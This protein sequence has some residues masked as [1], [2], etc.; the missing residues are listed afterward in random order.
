MRNDEIA[1]EGTQQNTPSLDIVVDQGN[2]IK[3]V[4]GNW[5]DKF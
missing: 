2:N 4:I 5:Y 1:Q 3:F